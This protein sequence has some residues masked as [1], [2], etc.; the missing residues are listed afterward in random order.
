M[1]TKLPHYVLPLYPAIAILI[2]GVLD[3]HALSRRLW[4]ERGTVWWF[5]ITL[6][7]AV[8]T[9]TANVY[10]EQQA[11]LRAWPFLAGAVIL[12]F[13]AWW[14][15]QVDGAEAFAAARR[16]C[17][18]PD[19][20][21]GV[22]IHVPASALAV[23]G[24]CDRA[25]SARRW[26]YAEIAAAGY[27][28]PSLIFFAGTDTLDTDGAG[29]AIFSMPGG[30][31]F[32]VVEKS[33]ERAFGQRADAIGLRYM[34]GPTIDGVDYS[35][36]RNVS[37]VI[38]RAGPLTPDDTTS[39]TRRRRAGLR[40][41]RHQ[42]QGLGQRAAAPAAP[43]ARGFTVAALRQLLAVAAIAILLSMLFVDQAAIHAV[44]K[45]PVWI[46]RA[47]NEFTD[48]GRSGKFLIPLGILILLMPSSTRPGWCAARA[49]SWRPLWCGLAFCL[50]R[51]R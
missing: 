20:D 26:L 16:R 12:A 3:H 18:D 31:R 49:S 23:P 6:A 37:I 5:L 44:A 13:G 15:Y 38:F 11:G 30:C 4:L 32:A 9:V 2:A 28:E 45:L 19:L 7:F 51:S 34:R 35:I 42:P 48:F 8:L 46:N 21:C 36:G 47:F 10:F 24:E 40:L 14:L 22:W 41:Y 17:L 50:P 33:E 1:I 39:P 25:L 27:Q 43:A 29:A